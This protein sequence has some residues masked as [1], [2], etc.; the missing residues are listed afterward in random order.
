MF[1]TFLFTCITT[2]ILH[3]PFVLPSYHTLF[4][5]IR[6]S[7]IWEQNVFF[8]FKSK[9]DWYLLRRS[10]I[11]SNTLLSLWHLYL[12]KDKPWSCSIGDKYYWFTILYSYSS[13]Y[14]MICIAMSTKCWSGFLFTAHTFISASFKKKHSKRVI[15]K[16]LCDLFFVL[17]QN[18]PVLYVI[19]KTWIFPVRR[20]IGLLLHEHCMG[21]QTRWRVHKTLVTSRVHPWFL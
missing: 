18:L 2:G 15:F 4:P 6:N 12:L 17:F 8:Y 11:W 10:Y 16:I 20:I 3:M 5:M 14:V 7:Q 13:P 1:G 21:V 9:T 19:M